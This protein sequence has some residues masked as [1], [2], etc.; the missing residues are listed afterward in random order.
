MLFNK[1][2]NKKEFHINNNFKKYK[3]LKLNK[4]F[5]NKYL[6]FKIINSRLSKE[7]KPEFFGT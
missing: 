5:E 4:R 7:G 1:C 3:I 2:K 6:I